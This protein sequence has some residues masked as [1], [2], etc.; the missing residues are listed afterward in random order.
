MS[1]PLGTVDHREEATLGAPVV[2]TQ[3]RTPPVEH[4]ALHALGTGCRP[5]ERNL[6]AGAV[7]PCPYVVGKLQHADH[8]CGYEVDVGDAVAV[9]QLQH[10]GRIEAVTHHHGGSAQQREDREDPL[11]RVVG[12]SAQQGRASR[13][14][15]EHVGERVCDELHHRGRNPCRAQG[16]T[17]TL[18]EPGGTRRV[19]HR[20][21]HEL[22]GRRIRGSIV[23]QLL[24]AQESLGERGSCG[25]TDDDPPIARAAALVLPCGDSDLYEAFVDQ[26]GTRSGVLDHVRELVRHPVPVDRHHHP[27]TVRSCGEHL[28]ELPPVATHQGDGVVGAQAQGPQGVHCPVGV[29]IELGPGR[30]A[31]LVDQGGLAGPAVDQLLGQFGHLPV[32]V[33][34]RRRW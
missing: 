20:T 18:G 23:E 21:T 25:R 14:Q 1:Q 6:E 3:D 28:E 7:E 29:V 31:E 17:N 32:P 10:L 19:E 34:K 12:R 16:G 15:T 4:V 2:L 26:H 5:V 8:L 24:P 27:A 22:F 30:L 11:C 33:T 13:R 9:D